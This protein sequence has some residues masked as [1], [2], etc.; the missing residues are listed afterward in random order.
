MDMIKIHA[1][2]NKNGAAQVLVEHYPTG[3]WFVVSASPVVQETA[4]FPAITWTYA[5]TGA[6]A[7]WDIAEYLELYKTESDMQTVLTELNNGDIKA[8]PKKV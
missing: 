3:R 2:R 1:S 8:I 5:F 6:I 7:R 4:I